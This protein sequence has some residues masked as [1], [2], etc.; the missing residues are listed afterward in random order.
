VSPIILIII[1]IIIIALFHF[2]SG[3]GSGVTATE[4]DKNEEREGSRLGE[5]DKRV[6][7]ALGLGFEPAVVFAQSMRIASRSG[8]IDDVKWMVGVQGF[9]R[10]SLCQ[11]LAE[12]REGRFALIMQVKDLTEPV[13]ELCD[14]LEAPFGDIAPCWVGVASDGTEHG[15]I[16]IPDDKFRG[17]RLSQSVQHIDALSDLFKDRGSILLPREIVVDNETK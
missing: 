17:L 6:V 16:N 7:V 5:A 9:L 11:C 8:V 1:I 15:T 4:E 14:F 13:F 2:K 12:N 10:E 3:F